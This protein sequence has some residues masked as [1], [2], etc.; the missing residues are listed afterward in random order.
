MRLSFLSLCLV[1]ACSSVVPTT[2]MRLGGLSPTTADPAGFAV[3]LSLPDGVGVQPGAARLIFEVK[4]TD[5]GE[6]STGTYVLTAQDGVYRIAED[7]LRALRAQQST[8]RAWEASQPDA[9]E[10][11]LS[12]NLTPCL[13]GAGPAPGAKVS[14]AIQIAQ[15]AP[16]LPLLRD[17]PLSAVASEAE[18]L[19]MPGCP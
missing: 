16:F 5:S 7:D 9:T 15:D 12:L 1:A 6:A 19:Q 14:V 18:I 11:A 17:A 13:I 3:D 8:A 10:G 4:R 2:V